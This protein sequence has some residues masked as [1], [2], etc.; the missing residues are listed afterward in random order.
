MDRCIPLPALLKVISC[1]YLGQYKS[2]TVGY[3]VVDLEK[4]P[5]FHEF[6][7]NTITFHGLGNCTGQRLYSELNVINLLFRHIWQQQQMPLNMICDVQES[8]GLRVN[9]G[10]KLTSLQV[11]RDAPT[12]KNEFHTETTKTWVKVK[13]G[14]F[15]GLQP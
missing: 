12:S 5:H 10:L 14:D 13:L 1:L 3:C 9:C 8:F 11:P 7:C 6:N 4:P 2:Y 15:T